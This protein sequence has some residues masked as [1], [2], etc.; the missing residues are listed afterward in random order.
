MNTPNRTPIETQLARF[1][2]VKLAGA[3]AIV[4]LVAVVGN[5]CNSAIKNFH[6]DGGT[7]FA[8]STNDNDEETY[9]DGGQPTVVDP[10][11]AP[12][13]DGGIN[14]E[15]K[16]D[17]K[18][19]GEKM[20]AIT[21]AL[22]K[23]YP[24]LPADAAPELN[25]SCE[26][27]DRIKGRLYIVR[28]ANNTAGSDQS[29]TLS[30]GI[31]GCSARG[32]LLNMNYSINEKG[33]LEL[34]ISTGELIFRQRGGVR[35]KILSSKDDIK[36]VLGLLDIVDEYKRKSADLNSLIDGYWDTKGLHYL[37]R[38]YFESRSGYRVGTGSG[39]IATCRLEE[40]YRALFTKRAHD[41]ET[42]IPREQWDVDLRYAV[43][44]DS[45]D[46]CDKE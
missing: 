43:E 16:S 1:R 33:E 22:A 10:L 18:R 38:G 3:A 40:T 31:R 37:N 24:F 14:P 4:A 21:N 42:P 45:G 35:F 30:D 6:D 5:K 41:A 12:K 23:K 8:T 28:T 29:L 7:T 11:V 26:V 25:P 13:A 2:R 19:V 36:T 20:E 34:D 15:E 27:Q 9:A 39:G 17:A 46:Y 32:N 44:Q